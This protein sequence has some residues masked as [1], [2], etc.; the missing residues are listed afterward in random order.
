MLKADAMTATSIMHPLSPASISMRDNLGSTG[1]FAISLPVFVREK[2]FLRFCFLAIAPNSVKR[3]K[4][5]L[6]LFG[7]G[8]SINGNLSI[9]PSFKSIIFKITSARFALNISGSVKTG[10]IL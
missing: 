6:I 9:S 10:L 7:A 3:L 5:S 1:I 4:P 2:P 8:L